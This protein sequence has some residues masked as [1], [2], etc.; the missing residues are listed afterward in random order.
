MKTHVLMPS[1]CKIVFASKTANTSSFFINYE[2]KG[3]TTWTMSG[4][5]HISAF[6]YIDTEICPLFD[7]PR[8]ALTCT[9]LDRTNDV[10]TRRDFRCNEKGVSTLITYYC[11]LYETN[12]NGKLLYMPMY[13]L[14]DEYLI[15]IKL[16][17]TI[18]LN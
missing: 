7:T 15:D 6:F 12:V 18:N 13:D 8:V 10:N 4:Y 17:F 1:P 14:L 9:E 3:N 16:F 5:G 2:A 11:Y